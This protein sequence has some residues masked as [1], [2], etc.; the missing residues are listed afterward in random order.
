M[1]RGG[2]GSFALEW[3]V[4]GAEDENGKLLSIRDYGHLSFKSIGGQML[5][6]LVI[7]VMG[8]CVTFASLHICP[9]F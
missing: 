9:H 1:V 7:S 4:M 2:E 8:L 6:V 3:V 5:T